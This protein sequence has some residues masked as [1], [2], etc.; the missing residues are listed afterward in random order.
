MEISDK[1]KKNEILD[2]YHDLLKKVQ[3]TK[4]VSHQE[5][6]SKR[7]AEEV[8]VKAAQFDAEQIVTTLGQVKIMVSQSLGLL[9]KKLTEE[10]DPLSELQS[11]IK[12]ESKNLEELHQIKK[13]ADSLAALLLAQKERQ[14]EF[15]QGMEERKEA[16]N[17]EIEGKRIE[18]K[19][20]KE[21]HD[22]VKAEHDS[23]L[24]KERVRDEE[25]YRYKITLERKKDNDSYES[26]KSTLERDL[27][28]KKE[29]FEKECSLRQT[30]LTE[31][32]SEV[33]A[34]R[35]RVASFPKELEDA[36]ALKENMI[37]ES[38]EREY[39]YTTNLKTAEIEGER[40]LQQQTINSLQAKIKEQETLIR[41]LSHKTEAAGLQ[42]QSI[43]L[44][45]LEG[46][47]NLTRSERDEHKLAQQR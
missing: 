44:K 29:S 7:Q 26:R 4:E 33:I 15:E 18:W 35:Q 46:A 8:V 16:L 40:K 27:L 41:D 34:L 37:Q 20:E 22:Q 5:V 30:A 36:L 24:K 23:Q 6:Q 39:R 9:E 12:I 3:N 14:K 42:V 32:E 25:E 2:A 1:S 21:R 43:A 28:E 10:Y 47:T 11:A 45:A 31:S 17:Q 13:N 38:L 19:L